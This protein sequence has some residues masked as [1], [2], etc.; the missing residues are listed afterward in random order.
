MK[1][2]YK[3]FIELNITDKVFLIYG[4]TIEEMSVTKIEREKS[5]IAITFSGYNFPIRIELTSETN[6]YTRSDGNGKKIVITTNYELVSREM[7]RITKDNIDDLLSTIRI[8]EN[9]I[10]KEQENLKHWQNQ[11]SNA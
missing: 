6:E 9:K 11:W 8:A 2:E 1:K 3:K 10:K 5:G 4:K 7:I